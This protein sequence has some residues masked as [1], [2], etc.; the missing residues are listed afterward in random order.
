MGCNNDIFS[1]DVKSQ[2]LNSV[3]TILFEQLKKVSKVGDLSQ[4]WPEGSLFN[5]YYTKV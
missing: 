3:K 5:S 1:T 4:G 2:D